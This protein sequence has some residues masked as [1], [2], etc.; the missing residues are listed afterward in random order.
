MCIFLCFCFS[1]TAR[2]RQHRQAERRRWK[3]WTRP[4]NVK[5]RIICLCEKANHFPLDIESLPTHWLRSDAAKCEIFYVIFLMPWHECD[6]SL[7]TA[8]QTILIYDLLVSLRPLVWSTVAATMRRIVLLICYC[9][10]SIEKLKV[11]WFNIP[12]VWFNC[13]FLFS[14]SQI[15][16][17][18][19]R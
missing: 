2:R 3:K 6:I 15:P 14:A 1:F 5:D 16:N 7:T 19:K 18:I 8:G 13:N 9:T 4:A 12:V 11:K 10:W 17:I